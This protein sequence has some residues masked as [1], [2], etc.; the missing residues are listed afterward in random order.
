MIKI[1]SKFCKCIYSLHLI[2]YFFF[3]VNIYI[4][5]SIYIYQLKLTK[6]IHKNIIRWH[7]SSCKA[8]LENILRTGALKVSSMC[9]DFRWVTDPDCVQTQRMFQPL[10][11]TQVWIFLWSIKSFMGLNN[12]KCNRCNLFPCVVTSNLKPIAL[13]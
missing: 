4:Y 13:K 7:T 2:F 9:T 5:I 6:D 3:S 10:V 1:S 11:H 12:P 8:V